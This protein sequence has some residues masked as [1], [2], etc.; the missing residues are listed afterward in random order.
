MIGGEAHEASC[1]HAGTVL[2]PPGQ[3]GQSSG[4]G[5]PDRSRLGALPSSRHLGYASRTDPA[6]GGG[7]AQGKDFRLAGK[8]AGGVGVILSVDSLIHMK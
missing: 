1:Q 8:A 5:L 7:R 4:R 2:W 6:L 3:G